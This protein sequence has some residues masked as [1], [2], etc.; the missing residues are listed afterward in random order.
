MVIDYIAIHRDILGNVINCKVIPRKLVAPQHQLFVMD[1]KISK[2]R[3]IK[4]IR[5]KR[6]NWWKLKTE[7][8]E[9]LRQKLAE[10]MVRDDKE[11]K[12]IWDNT[13]AKIIEI[14]K[15]VLGESRSGTFLEIESW[16]WNEE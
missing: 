13:Y 8:G 11:E 1:L 3:R 16:W 2:K 10:F 9:E 7:K 6:I 15:E 12:L 4:R 5:A 14:A